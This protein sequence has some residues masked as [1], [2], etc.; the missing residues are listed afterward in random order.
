MTHRTYRHAAPKMAKTI[1]KL[2]LYMEKEK[3]HSVDRARTSKYNIPDVMDAGFAKLIEQGV[4]MVVVDEGT[5]V[6]DEPI[7]GEDGDLDV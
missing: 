1:K 6:E 2:R 7:N 5:N 4:N 3:T